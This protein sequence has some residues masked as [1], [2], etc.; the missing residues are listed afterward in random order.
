MINDKGIES[1]LNPIAVPIC[2]AG[3]AVSIVFQLRDHQGLAALSSLS[4]QVLKDPL[5]MSQLTDRVYELLRDDLR[6]Q[7]ERMG[8]YGNN[9]G[10]TF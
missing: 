1:V 5:L 2:P 10:G 7:R 6:Q 9:E 3:Y 4:A 8:C